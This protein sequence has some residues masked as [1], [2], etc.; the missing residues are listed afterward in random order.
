M[1]KLL[2][3]LTLFLSLFC[4]FNVQATVIDLTQ[5]VFNID[6]TVSESGFYPAG[7][8]P[9][10]SG[11]TGSLD[12]NGLGSLSTQ[13]SGAGNHNVTLMLDYE[14]DEANN[15]FFNEYG[16]T[17]GS[18]ASLTGGSLAALQSWEIDEAFLFGD[19]YFN[20]LDAT[21][22]NSNS[23]PNGL[24]DD[25]AFALGWD[26]TLGVD[27]IA[28]IDFSISDIL[29][30]P[31]FYL[32]HHDAETGTGYDELSSLYFW[33]DLSISGITSGNT[34]IDVPEPGTAFLFGIGILGI[35]LSSQRRKHIKT[36]L[37]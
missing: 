28:T 16:S 6:G 30:A 27:E 19:I 13:V 33:S 10:P 20:T 35:L 4:A 29:D 9:L 23:V 12:T 2:S 24:N 17:G 1:S 26:F 14:I 36:E 11:V 7:V 34:P 21:L 5:W 8:E 3:F 18:L 37:K 31:E 25:V 32:A 15:T 22:D